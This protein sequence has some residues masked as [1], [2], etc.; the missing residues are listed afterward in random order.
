MKPVKKNNK[1]LF[2]NKVTIAR[3]EVLAMNKIYG[4]ADSVPD[5]YT[6]TGTSVKGTH[7]LQTCIT[8]P[9]G[10]VY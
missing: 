7:D 10:N 2:L 6:D 8:C 1:K 5:D 3:L 9:I 4:G